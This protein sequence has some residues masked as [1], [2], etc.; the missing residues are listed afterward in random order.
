MDKYLIVR[1]FE[2][3]LPVEFCGFLHFCLHFQCVCVFENSG[4]VCNALYKCCVWCSNASFERNDIWWEC[5]VQILRF[6]FFQTRPNDQNYEFEKKSKTISAKSIFI[7]M[8]LSSPGGMQSFLK[9]G[10]CGLLEGEKKLNFQYKSR[11]ICQCH[12]LTQS[13]RSI[14]LI[15]N[16]FLKKIF[17]LFN[18]LVNDRTWIFWFGRTEPRTMTK[19]TEPVPNQNRTFY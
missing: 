9:I 11:I 1:I 15:N 10:L 16:P 7:F 6:F 19:I 4:S 8:F 18:Q 12:F 5:N 2:L 13:H 3:I 17:V 14:F